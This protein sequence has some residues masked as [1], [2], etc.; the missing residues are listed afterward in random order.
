MKKYW[1]P[2]LSILSILLVNLGYAQN[3]PMGFFPSGGDV[4]IV[5]NV[6]SMDYNP[7][8]SEYRI[9]GGGANMWDKTDAFHFVWKKISG[10]LSI[11]AS[12]A[13]IGD[14]VNPHRKACLM[15]RQSLEADSPYVDLALHG[16]G[17]TSLQYRKAPGAITEEVK[18]EISSPRAIRLER[19]GNI[20]KMFVSERRRQLRETGSVELNLNDP[21][22]IGLAVCSHDDNVLET[23][24]FSDVKLKT[25]NLDSREGTMIESSLEIV[26]VKTEERK[27]VY[28]SPHHFEAPNWSR[29]G[30]Y[31][32]FNSG[33]RMYTLPLLGGEPATLNTAFAGRC[34][35]DHGFSPD[36]SLLAIGHHGDDNA[37]RIYVLPANGGEPKLVTP[38]GP[39]YWH[40][41]SPDGKTLAYCAERDGEYDVYTIPVEGGEETRLTQSP[42]LDDGPD[43]SPDGEWIYFNSMRTGTMKI[44][45]MKTDGS[46]QEQVTFDELNDWFPHPSPDGKWLAFVTYEKGVE[47]HPPNKDVLLRVAPIAGGKPRILARLFGGQGTL[48]VPSWSPDGQWIAFVSYRLFNP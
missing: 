45:R 9:S 3:F 32:L 4:G 47:G 36:G 14:G 33:G 1:I 17:L 42:G 35:N 15:I 40:G 18:S 16:D 38:Q 2:P 48:N 28:R 46:Q 30:K 37:S 20:F 31:F 34:N 19:R 5:K 11:G 21:V 27:T 26:N 8:R 10:D 6:G 23:A 29:D 24:V 41:W 39:S 13:W 7:S 43:Y 25:G 44:W 22:Y 12:V